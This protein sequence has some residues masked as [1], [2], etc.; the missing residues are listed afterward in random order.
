MLFYVIILGF[1]ALAGVIINIL[2]NHKDVVYTVIGSIVILLTGGFACFVLYYPFY[3]D[4]FRTMITTLVIVA[5]FFIVIYISLRL[6]VNAVSLRNEPLSQL[7]TGASGHASK[8]ANRVIS[9]PGTNGRVVKTKTIGTVEVTRLNKTTLQNAKNTGQTA[10][11]QPSSGNVSTVRPA[12]AN[13]AR[14]TEPVHTSFK[15]VF[16]PQGASGI[17]QPETAVPSAEDAA[18]YS[19][20]QSEVILVPEDTSAEKLPVH[21]TQPADVL[22]DEAPAETAQELLVPMSETDIAPADAVRTETTQEPTTQMPET[23]DAALADEGSTEI[24]QEPPAHI[25]ESDA[26]AQTDEESDETAQ[27]PSTMPEM[28]AAAQ[29]DETTAEIVQESTAHMPDTDTAVQA[30]DESAEIV[31]ILPVLQSETVPASEQAPVA[32]KYSMLL[33]KAVELIEDD[34]YA[35]AMQLLAACLSGSSSPAQQKQAD[36]LLLECLTLSEQYD[37]ARKKWLEVLN[38][39]Y[40]L[41][42]SDKLKLKHILM[43]IDS[44]NRQVS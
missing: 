29:P 8:P 14:Q 42:P 43:K 41:E 26:E 38:K 24:A 5:V 36:I 12:Q 23:V 15:A 39:M 16:V 11:I 2:I 34:K 44:R 3:F 28:N 19:A 32:D 4:S 18:V 31:H 33:D 6:L 30:A 20:Q 37:Q 10:A 17:Q 9:R 21:P 27:E 35:Y 13:A 40:I 7:D 22:A 1:G 25:L